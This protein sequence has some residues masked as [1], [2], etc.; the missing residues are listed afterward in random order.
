MLTFQLEQFHQSIS[1][2]ISKCHHPHKSF[3]FCHYSTWCVHSATPPLFYCRTD[4]AVQSA[5]CAGRITVILTEPVQRYQRRVVKCTRRVNH[6]SRTKWGWYVCRGLAKVKPL[7]MEIWIWQLN[8]SLCQLWTINDSL[9]VLVV[10]YFN[11]MSTVEHL[12]WGACAL[13]CHKD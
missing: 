8:L 10:I 6:T 3:T 13:G 2:A 11:V 4:R 5:V 1:I 7:P 12:T 9:E